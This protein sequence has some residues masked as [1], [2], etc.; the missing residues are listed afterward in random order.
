MNS[1]K[2][3]T[4]T[5]TNHFIAFWTLSVSTRVSQY[6]KVH[7]AIFWIF[8]CKMKTTQADAPTIRMDCHPNQTNWCPNLCHPHHFYT[9]CPSWHNPPNL[10][11]LGTGIKYAG[12]HTRWLGLVIKQTRLIID[13]CWIFAHILKI[14][15]DICFSSSQNHDDQK[16]SNST[17]LH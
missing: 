11:W 9:K 13:D 16:P 2:T 4:H 5:H 3:N 15:M 7:F 10:S 8:G 12:L 1:N 6:Q 17:L 14:T